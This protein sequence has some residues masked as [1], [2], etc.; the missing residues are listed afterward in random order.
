MR[1]NRRERKGETRRR[2][3]K[4]EVDFKRVKVKGEGVEGFEIEGA[5][6]RGGPKNDVD[7]EKLKSEE[8]E[9]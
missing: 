4:G 9:E 8:E 2:K 3:Q 5:G 7:A 6:R 1:K